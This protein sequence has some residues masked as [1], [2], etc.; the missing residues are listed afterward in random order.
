MYGT[1]G[2]MDFIA[3]FPAFMLGL[4]FVLLILGIL[5][6]IGAAAGWL[7]L[8]LWKWRDREEKALTY[9]T[10]QVAV[11]RDNEVKIDAM[12]QFF[13]SLYTLFKSKKILFDWIDLT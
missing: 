9:V 8:Q 1:S 10:L 7:F 6:G 12:E 11:P 2:L 3:N 4:I 5:I 13:S